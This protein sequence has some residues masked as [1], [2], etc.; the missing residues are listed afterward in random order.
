M[1]IFSLNK[2]MHD[3]LLIL[4]SPELLE[5]SVLNFIFELRHISEEKSICISLSTT[6]TFE[7]LLAKDVNERKRSNLASRMI[8]CIH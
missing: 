7:C 6:Q 1:E 4:I 8:C 2:V 5:L 3:F